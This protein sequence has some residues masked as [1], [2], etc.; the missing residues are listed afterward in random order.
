[1]RSAFLFI[2]SLTCSLLLSGCAAAPSDRGIDRQ[3]PE[4]RLGYRIG[5]YLQIEGV[6]SEQGKSGNSTLLV[7][8]VNGKAIE[9]PTPIWLDNL[10]LPRDER[11]AISGYESGRWIGIPPDV[12]AHERQQPRQAAWQLRIYFVVTSVQSP[13]SLR[14][15]ATNLER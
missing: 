4:G 7:D 8:R 13:E 5:T 6:R 9:P 10:E 2:A 15:A 1:M 12:E 11:C 14:L 3:P